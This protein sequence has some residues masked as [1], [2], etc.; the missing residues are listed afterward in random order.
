MLEPPK[1]ASLTP[2]SFGE[3]DVLEAEMG[4]H[5]AIRLNV[6]DSAGYLQGP[7]NTEG[8]RARMK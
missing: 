2:P 5:D 4:V 8:V 1:S 3:K 6:S 7:S